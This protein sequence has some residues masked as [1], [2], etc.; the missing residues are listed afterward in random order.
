MTESDASITHVSDTGLWVAMYRAMENDRPD[1]IFRDPYARRLAGPRGE[2]IVRAMPQGLD[3]A[4]AMIVRTKIFDEILLR[5][6]AEQR[7]DEVLNLAA[8]LDVRPYRLAL[9]ATLRWTDVDFPDVIEYKRKSLEGEKAACVYEGVGVDLADTAARRV[10]L[11]RVDARSTRV[12]VVTEG[13]LI[14]L[15][16]DEVSSLAADL[17]ARPHFAYWL[18]DLANSLLLQFMNRTWG[19]RLPEG[20]ARFQFAIDDRAAFFEPLGW[21]EIEYRGNWAEARRL[22]RRMR[23]SW[24]WDIIAMLQPPSQRKKYASMAGSLLMERIQPSRT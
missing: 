9:P 13:L 17:A 18:T 12:L 1:A 22:D 20:R 24:L 11:D 21:R 16:A 4:W 5:L 10:L 14:Y 19:K 7:I 2:R 23:H 15:N 8:G 3:Q 6:V